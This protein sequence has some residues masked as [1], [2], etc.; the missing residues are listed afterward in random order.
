MNEMAKKSLFNQ[1]N[2]SNQP[3]FIN[4]NDFNDTD[5]RNRFEVIG[6]C[7][8]PIQKWGQIYDEDTAYSVGTI[9]P[10]LNKPFLGGG[11]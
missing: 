9:F 6:I 2:Q 11:R 8:V 4:F 3:N 5:G 7:Y 1:A 10:E